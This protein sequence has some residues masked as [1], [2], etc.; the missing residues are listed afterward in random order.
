[1]KLL[2]S[3]LVAICLI[4]IPQMAYSGWGWLIFHERSFK[5]RVIDAETKEPIAGA[6]VV[7]TYNTSV[8]GPTGTHIDPTD[9]QE[10]ITDRNG[11][12]YLKS[13]TRVIYPLSVGEAADFLVWKPDYK[14]QEIVGRY[15]IPHGHGSVEVTSQGL[16]IAGL[17]KCKTVEER[18]REPNGPLGDR[19]DWKKQKH[20]TDMLRE[21]HEYITGTPAPNL[22]RTE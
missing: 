22:Y 20:F 18:R 16:I 1:M 14:K 7:V 19:K 10:A 5:G 17:V 21:E 2:V 4:G 3:A 6:V 12:F 11:E 9:Y 8:L 13:F 15:F